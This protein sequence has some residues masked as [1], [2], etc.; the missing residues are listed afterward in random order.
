MSSRRKGS[1]DNKQRGLDIRVITKYLNI[2][3][4]MSGALLIISLI[5]F[6]AARDIVEANVVYL[7]IIIFNLL[8]VIGVWIVPKILLRY[9]EKISSREKLNKENEGGKQ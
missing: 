5:S 6:F 4:A 3:G 9:F 1:G 8:I 2:I 7:M